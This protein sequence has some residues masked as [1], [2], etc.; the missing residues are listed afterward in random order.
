MDEPM[1]RQIAEDLHGRIESDAVGENVT[2]H[3][4][5]VLG[6]LPSLAQHHPRRAVTDV[7]QAELDVPGG[8]QVFHP[9]AIRLL[10]R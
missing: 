8:E 5:R 1:Y 10:S 2:P 6:R 7:L 9:G 3:R 4:V